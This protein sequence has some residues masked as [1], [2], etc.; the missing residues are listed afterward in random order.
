VLTTDSVEQALE[1]SDEGRANKGREAAV[2][3]MRM[4]KVLELAG[5]I[6]LPNR[7]GFAA[8]KR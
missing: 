6:A 3:A 2:T 7:V 5:S 8:G 1:R 4:V